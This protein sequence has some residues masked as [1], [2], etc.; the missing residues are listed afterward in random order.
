MGAV[1]G[2]PA[3]FR[4]NVSGNAQR[5]AKYRS[6]HARLDV[7]VSPAIGQSIA[8][9]SLQFEASK[10]EVVNSLLR[11]ALTNRDWKKQGLLWRK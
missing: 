5:V 7:A 1:V 8:D 6:Q 4:K 9:L 2:S 3:P 10:N 11:W